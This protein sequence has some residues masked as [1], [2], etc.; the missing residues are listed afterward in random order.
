MEKFQIANADIV[1][2]IEKGLE[3][4]TTKLDMDGYG[5]QKRI[6]QVSGVQVA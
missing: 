4:R 5:I 6:D 3:N 2:G 1:P